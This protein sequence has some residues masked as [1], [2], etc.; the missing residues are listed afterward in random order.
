[1]FFYIHMLILMLVGKIVGRVP[2]LNTN[3][4]MYWSVRFI[5]TTIVSLVVV[6]ISQKTMGKRILKWI[7]FV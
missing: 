6:G 3:W 2:W 7:G 1:M 4:V 5:L